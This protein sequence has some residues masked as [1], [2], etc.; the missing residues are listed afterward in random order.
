MKEE[1]FACSVSPQEFPSVSPK[2]YK[3]LI[4][5]S[6][7]EVKHYKLFYYC[8]HH[9]VYLSLS[10]CARPPVL[11]EV[12]AGVTAVLVFEEVVNSLSA[13]AVKVSGSSSRLAD[14]SYRFISLC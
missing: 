13:M 6:C 3:C 12:H 1:T 14:P 8:L 2:R 10:L 9:T 5:C 11:T 4:V 7:Y